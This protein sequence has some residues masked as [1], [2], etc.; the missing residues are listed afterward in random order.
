MPERF[1]A[2]GLRWFCS[3]SRVQSA[4]AGQGQM[5]LPESDPLKLLPSQTNHSWSNLT[6]VWYDSVYINSLTNLDNF[7]LMLSWKWLENKS[8]QGCMKA[9]L[10][11]YCT[12]AGISSSYVSNRSACLATTDCYCK[13]YLSCSTS[14]GVIKIAH[15]LGGAC[16]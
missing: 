8:A 3:Q 6:P 7:F 13:V 5:W 12:A 14:L 4:A 2:L 9:T 15:G 16:K 10:N 1:I 11:M